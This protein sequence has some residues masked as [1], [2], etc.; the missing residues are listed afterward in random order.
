MWQDSKLSE[1]CFYSAKI[2]YAGTYIRS[3]HPE[4]CFLK[5]PRG[6][7]KKI[8]KILRKTPDSEFFLKKDTPVKFAKFLKAPFLYN[9]SSGCFLYMTITNNGR[10]SHWS[11]SNKIG[12]LRNFTKFTGKHL[13]QSLFY[14]V[15]GLGLDSGTGVFLRI[16]W[17]LKQHLLY[18]TPL[19][20]C[21]FTEIFYEMCSM[22]VSLCAFILITIYSKFVL[23]VLLLFH[24]F[25][26]IYHE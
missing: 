10:S 14:K 11:C 13:C 22:V 23:I 2:Y 8:R 9:T 7:F 1:L 26:F 16:L 6:F 20:E 18:R 3:S 21:F 24:S 19:D 15:A 12:V 5:A 25:G 17:I 4:G